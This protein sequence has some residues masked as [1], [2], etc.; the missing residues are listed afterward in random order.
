MSGRYSLIPKA[1]AKQAIRIRRYLL[2]S[3]FS[4]LYLCALGALHLA[5]RLDKRVLYEA[6]L[7]VLAL[8]MLFFLSFRS[9]LNLK[10]K[11]PSLTAWQ[12]M[13]AIM[14]M[15]YVVYRA[16]ASREIFASFLFIALMFGMLRLPR[17]RLV[18][19][20]ATSLAAFGAVIVAH[21]R[22]GAPVQIIERDL[23]QWLILVIT[24]PWFILIGG[25]IGRL[26]SELAAAGTKIESIEERARRD[27]LTG[28][29][30]RRALTAAMQAEKIRCDRSGALYSLCI[31]D[32]DHFKRIND[33]LGHLAGD[34]VLRCFAEALQ[35]RLRAADIFGRYGGDEF[36]Q[37]LTETSLEGA[38]FDAER[39]RQVA[40]GL[41]FAKLGQGFRIT[42]SIG[43]AQ[44]G[45]GESA[46]DTFRHADLA[47]Y[48]AK[49]KGRNRVAAWG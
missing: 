10:S 31:I 48:E 47:L 12:M 2:A 29:H 17:R 14:T 38:L 30:N 6:T 13:S 15:L 46:M 43:V 18:V 16:E 41:T 37:I 49:L 11:D 34:E 23:M 35:A 19:L 21:A 45:H 27:E 24:I 39:I 1:D 32:I 5:G 26:R 33:E 42:V 9:G 7:L 20:A 44:Y 25:Y 3:T 8:I 28:A 4:L 40:A 22:S 36:V